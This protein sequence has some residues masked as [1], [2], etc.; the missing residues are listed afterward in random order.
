[1]SYHD[2]A[3]NVQESF[4][5][6]LMLGIVAGLKDNYQI[7]SNRESGLG[8]YDVALFPKDQNNIGLVMEFKAGDVADNQVEQL[9]MAAL[10]Q[11][12]QQSYDRGLKDAGVENIISLG[13][14]FTKN[15][16]R[17]LQLTAPQAP[18]QC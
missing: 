14:G 6:G 10:Q 18:R 17:V 9:A 2:K 11:L 7:K 1:M 12:E 4:I 8:R 5:H 15:K 3:K 13:I 16:V